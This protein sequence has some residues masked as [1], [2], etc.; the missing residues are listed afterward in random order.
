MSHIVYVNLPVADAARA[1][2]FYEGLGFS[3][4]EQFTGEHTICIRLTEGACLMLLDRETFASFA[5]GPGPVADPH[6]STG[7]LVAIPRDIREA[8]DAIVEAAVAHGGSD[9]GRKQEYGD[10]M[11]GRCFRDPDGNTFEPGW[12]DTE[13]M[14]AAMAAQKG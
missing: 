10:V 5:P 8:V 9:T 6:E 3:T 1:R 4:V 13:K 12:M 7:V 11:Y 14:R 2:A